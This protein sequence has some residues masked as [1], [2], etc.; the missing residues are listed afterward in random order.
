M[1]TGY[2]QGVPG[3][4]RGQKSEVAAGRAV[5][6]ALAVG[7]AAFWMWTLLTGSVPGANERNA[8]EGAQAVERTPAQA[9]ND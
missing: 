6:I 4:S 9:D 7:V 1:I 5:G 3:E 2:K 8:R